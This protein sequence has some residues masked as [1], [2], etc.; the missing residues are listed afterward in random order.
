MYDPHY[1]LNYVNDAACLMIGFYKGALDA[2]GVQAQSAPLFYAWLA[3]S[4]FR[5]MVGA[6]AGSVLYFFDKKWWVEG[7]H[8]PI[9]QGLKEGAKGTVISSLELAVGYGAGWG[10]GKLWGHSV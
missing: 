10:L 3:T 6:R 2:N 5:G 4:A 8:Q 7:K 9:R 1:R